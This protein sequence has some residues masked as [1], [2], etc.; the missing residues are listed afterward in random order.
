VL[1]DYQKMDPVYNS[2]KLIFK[3]VQIIKSAIYLPNRIFSVSKHFASYHH[4]FME[5]EEGQNA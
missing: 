2:I 3:K 1:W 4:S 5:G